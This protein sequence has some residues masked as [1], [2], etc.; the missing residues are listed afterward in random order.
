VSKPCQQRVGLGA[1]AL[2]LP[3][4]AQACC[5]AQ[6][7]RFRLLATGDVQGLVKAGFGLQRLLDGLPQ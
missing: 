6:L 5:G 1:L 7:Q 4:A 2:L 3:Q